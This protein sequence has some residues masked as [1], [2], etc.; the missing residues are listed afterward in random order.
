MKNPEVY[1]GVLLL[2][3]YKLPYMIQDDVI[4]HFNSYRELGDQKRKGLENSP[5]KLP[6]SSTKTLA[7]SSN[8]IISQAVLTLRQ[9]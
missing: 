2:F 9:A 6:F 3:L 7:Y 4:L 8:S 5:S 1:Q